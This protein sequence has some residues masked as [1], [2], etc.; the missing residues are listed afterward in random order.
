M[1]RTKM[2][3]EKKTEF[4]TALAETGMIAKSCAAISVAR[5]TVYRWRDE[6]PVFRSEWDKAL[7]IG[8]TALEDEAHR[9]AFEG[10]EEP[11]F[12]QGTICGTVRKY[13]DTLAI[14]LLKAHAPEK[15]RENSH[16]QLTGLNSGPVEIEHR[17][18]RIT[19]ILEAAAAR[20]KHL[21]ENLAGLV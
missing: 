1:R 4:C 7:K 16:I 10:I 5:Q 12:H 15:Y 3:L 21:E 14:F 2:T 17:A 6:D 20:K 8:I 11:I 18:D 13:S 9:R 19:T